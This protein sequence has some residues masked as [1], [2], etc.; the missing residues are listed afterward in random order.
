MSLPEMDQYLLDV[1]VYFTAKEWTQFSSYERICI[2]NVKENYEMM[3][4]VGLQVNPP[5]FMQRQQ[6]M[7]IEIKEE[8]DSEDEDMMLGLQVNPP[9]FMQRQQEIKIEIKEE[10]D[11]EDEEMMLGTSG[12][13][14]TF[15]C[16]CRR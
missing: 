5:M 6:E 11:S 1:Q 14:R 4:K 8:N 9:K 10:N 12:T 2:K 7:K 16:T 13:R 15:P 3:N